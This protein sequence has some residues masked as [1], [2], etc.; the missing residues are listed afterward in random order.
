MQ[1]FYIN[2][3]RRPDRRV[4]MEEQFARLGLAATRVA[5]ATPAVLSPA[6]VARFCDPRHR[7]WLTPE[8]LSCSHSHLRTYDAFLATG[9]PWA[10]IFEDDAVLSARLPSFLAAFD[11][12]P[13]PLDLVR[14]ETDFHRLVI[15]RRGDMVDGIRLARYVGWERGSAGYLVSR[16]AAALHLASDAMRRRATDVALFHHVSPTW[17]HLAVRQADPALCSQADRQLDAVVHA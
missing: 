8:E 12:A 2:L 15:H 1:I 11:A 9:A 6:E 14:L 10:A 4:F 3:E 13:P 17:R 16:R 7:L 5:A